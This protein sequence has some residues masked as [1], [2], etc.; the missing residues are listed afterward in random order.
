MAVEI[1]NA[2]P[3]SLGEHTSKTAFGTRNVAG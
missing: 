2:K 1:T 3:I